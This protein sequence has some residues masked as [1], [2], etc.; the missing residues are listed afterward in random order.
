MESKVQ[1]VVFNKS[2]FNVADATRWCDD[3][4]FKTGAI[5]E[6][7]DEI[8]VRQISSSYARSLGYSH[9]GFKQIENGVSLLIVLHEDGNIN[10]EK[11]LKTTDEI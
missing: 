1:S 11:D 3:N 10:F 6:T 2:G 9:F 4:G 5:F 8:R 7:V